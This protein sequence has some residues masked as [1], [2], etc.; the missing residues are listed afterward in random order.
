MDWKKI[1]ALLLVLGIL[2]FIPLKCNNK[3]KDKYEVL[4]EQ[5]DTQKKE[6]EIV[7]EKRQ[8]EKDSLEFIIS[9]REVYNNVLIKEN[10]SL[11]DR[12]SSVKNRTFTAPKDLIGLVGYFNNRIGT[13]ENIVL[14]NKVGLGQFSAVKVITDLEEGDKAIEIVPLQIEVIKNQDTIIGN[15]NKDKEDLNILIVSAEDEIQKREELQ[16]LAKDNIN[17]L[18]KQ[19]KKANNKNFWNKVLIGVGAVSG[20]LIGKNL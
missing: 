16:D 20:F 4:K 13:K 8:K 1:T 17:S 11:L 3:L 5:Y 12:I 18:E 19:V 6:L 10:I 9:Q 14:G 7:S 2:L 15:L